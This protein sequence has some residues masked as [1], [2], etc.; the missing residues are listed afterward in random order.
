MKC[1]KCGG[2]IP[3]FDLKPKC[4]HC[5]VNILYYTQEEDLMRDAKRTELEGA[6][7][8]MTIQ[9]VKADFIG[10]KLVIVR[11]IITL[12]SAAA[13]LVPYGSVNYDMPF[14]K[15]SFSAGI[16]GIIQSVTGG[17]LLKLPAFL[18]GAATSKQTLTALVPIG[19]MAA[20]LVIDLLIALALL[21][22]FLNLTR[23]TK[24]MRKASLAGAIIAGIGQAAVLVMQFTHGDNSA[25]NVSPGFGALVSCAVFV[26]LF[27][28]NGLVLKKGIEPVYK[29]NDLKRKEMLKRVRAGEV[30]LDSLPLP[31][32]ESEEERD[33]RL[34][35]LKEA[36][37]AEEEGKEL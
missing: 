21:L 34:N 37:K 31:V 25:A 28:I 22:G 12:I 30:D 5:G 3:F 6:V 15:G 29:E 20:I 4:K 23:S 2:E 14:F 11:L 19:F 24:F 10:S 32:F 17:L 33:K 36:M 1:P 26:A 9:R 27:I 35:D 13:L 7:A 8:R 16:I 18:G